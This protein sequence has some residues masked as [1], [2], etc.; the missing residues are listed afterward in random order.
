MNKNIWDNISDLKRDDFGNLTWEEFRG[1]ENTKDTLMTKALTLSRVLLAI[2]AEYVHLLQRKVQEARKVKELPG[3]YRKHLEGVDEN[4]I[5][6]LGPEFLYFFMHVIDRIALAFLGDGKR[7]SFMNYLYM[8]VAHEYFKITTGLDVP[9]AGIVSGWFGEKYNK[10]QNEYSK[11]KII[12]P[13]N[14]KIIESMMPKNFEKC[15]DTLFGE[16]SKKIERLLL[17]NN[18]YDLDFGFF[19]DVTLANIIL[20]YNHLALQRL[21]KEK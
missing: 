9:F 3:Y 10:C 4:K 8:D 5:N 19:A 16:F 11:Y 7:S 2:S 20:G 17:E 12:L 18:E 1:S 21:L 6:S 15:K 13:E 14:F